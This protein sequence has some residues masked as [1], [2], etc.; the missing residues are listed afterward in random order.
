MATRYQENT[1]AITIRKSK[2]TLNNE[3]NLLGA[4]HG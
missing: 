3:S 2:L 1:L 4:K